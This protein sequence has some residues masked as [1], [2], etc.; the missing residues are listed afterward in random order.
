MFCL[1]KPRKKS[2]EYTLDSNGP[3]E[4]AMNEETSVHWTECCI[5]RL[6]DD[7]DIRVRLRSIEHKY[8]MRYLKRAENPFAEGGQRI[9]YH[10]K[11]VSTDRL[12]NIG[13]WEKVVMKRFKTLERR[14]RHQDYL[15]LMETQYVAAFLAT[16]FNKVSPRG[17]KEIQFLKVRKNFFFCLSQVFW[18]EI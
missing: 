14:D 17:S 18:I 12:N 4:V 16:E 13:G 1:V 9:S 3:E 7:A 11:L 8:D 5:R 15:D 10:A 6:K 2:I